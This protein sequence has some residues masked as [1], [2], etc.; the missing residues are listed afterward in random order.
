MTNDMNSVRKEI[1]STKTAPDPVGPYSQ[2]VKAGNLLYISG[3]LPIDPSSGQLTGDEITE[4]TRQCLENLKSIL[5]AAGSDLEDV[6]K[7]SVFL[8]DL[9]DFN[10]M[11]KTYAQFFYAEQPAR[12]CVQV[13]KLPLDARVEIEA[14]AL[15]CPDYK[16]S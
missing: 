4:Q 6:L 1:I 16:A 12:C 7:V 13:A 14:I 11:N 10:A 8:K 9:S 15:I 5:T 2:S 3:Q